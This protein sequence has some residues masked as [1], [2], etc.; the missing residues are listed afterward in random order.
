MRIVVDMYELSE[1]EMKEKDLYYK[2]R[3][4]IYN[5]KIREL[6][7]CTLREENKDKYKIGQIIEE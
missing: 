3:I 2:N 4:V 6:E 7:D 5:S 1:K